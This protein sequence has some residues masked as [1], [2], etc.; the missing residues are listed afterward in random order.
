MLGG[1]KANKKKKGG[2][3]RI[4]RFLDGGYILSV[5]DHN[6]NAQMGHFTDCMTGLIN[7]HFSV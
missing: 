3:L 7:R 5:D 2:V 1:T 4:L 6:F